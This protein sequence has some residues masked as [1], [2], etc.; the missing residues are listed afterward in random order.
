MKSTRYF[1]T[2]SLHAC[3]ATSS[4]F[5]INRRH[6]GK[7]QQVHARAMCFHQPLPDGRLAHLQN[8]ELPLRCCFGAAVFGGG[9]FLE[10]GTPCFP[11]ECEVVAPSINRKSE[12]EMESLNYFSIL[13]E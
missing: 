10:L 12:K 3:C 6:I 13:E 8:D 1:F 2:F 11:L 5:P 9:R 7:K 4:S